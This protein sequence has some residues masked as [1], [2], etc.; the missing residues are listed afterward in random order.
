MCALGLKIGG[1]IRI[2]GLEFGVLG[3]ECWVLVLG[4][5]LESGVCG[6]GFS[7]WSLGCGVWG[8]GVGVEVLVFECEGEPAIIIPRDDNLRNFD[9]FYYRGKT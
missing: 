1:K 7:L 8:S 9:F 2:N 4:F 6:L 3:L 5:G